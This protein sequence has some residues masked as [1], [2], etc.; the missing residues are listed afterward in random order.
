MSSLK[1]RRH[2]RKYIGKI[3]E[4]RVE[5]SAEDEMF[6]GI[7]FDISEDGLSIISIYLLKEGQKIFMKSAA[8]LPS[9]TAI[10]Q[11]CKNYYD[12]YFKIGLKYI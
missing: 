10:V 2:R 7:L 9:N 8:A 12:L 6:D 11:W 5:S 3:L 1:Q 4:Y